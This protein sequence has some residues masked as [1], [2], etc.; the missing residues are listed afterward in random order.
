MQAPLII[1]RIRLLTKTVKPLGQSWTC[2]CR[3]AKPAGISSLNGALSPRR[4]LSMEAAPNRVW[5]AL[6]WSSV[7]Q[8]GPL[9]WSAHRLW[10]CSFIDSVASD[11]VQ[12]TTAFIANVL[13]S[14]W[15]RS[16]CD[17]GYSRGRAKSSGSPRNHQAT[18]ELV[19]IVSLTGAGLK[20]DRPVSWK[21]YRLTWRLLGIAMPLSIAGIAFL[22]SS[23]LGLGIASALLVGAV[24]APTDPVLASDV[25]V[26]PPGEGLEDDVR[27]TL[28]AEAGFNDG[29]AFPFVNLAIAIAIAN[30]SGGAWFGH[31]LT[32]DVIWKLVVAW[33]QA[34]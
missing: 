16:V 18:H 23:L 31:W 13:R 2:S 26:G 14:A 25:Q 19:V 22:G 30:Q 24:L 15:R 20:L 7:L 17:S 21:S 27:S 9:H 4:S 1:V 28:T 10:T 6:A 8:D 33:P 32:V 3:I 29:L 12:G 34:G 5:N 11:A